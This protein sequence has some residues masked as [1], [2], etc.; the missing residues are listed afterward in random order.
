[1]WRSRIRAAGLLALPLLVGSLACGGGEE[2]DPAA[3]QQEAVDREMEAALEDPAAEPELRDEPDAGSAA[4]RTSP[5]AAAT[6]RPAPAPPP[7]PAAATPVETPPAET[8]PS[9]EPAPRSYTVPA[10]TGFRVELEQELSTRTNRVGDRFTVRTLE[11]VTDGRYV[12]APTGTVLTGRITA[13][14]KSGGAGDPAI[15]KIAFD[16]IL[17]GE[18]PIPLQA[19]VTEANPNV[20][21]RSGTGERAAK[22]GGGAVAGAILGRVIGGGAKGAVVGGVVGAAAG[23]A[24]TLATED[25]DAVLP[26]GSELTLELDEPLV[27]TEGA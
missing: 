8:S 27:V 26:A 4:P 5:Q 6:P 24:I 25:K 17:I 2:V 13:L 15:I 12:V 11:P 10:G 9:A 3:E 1:M 16:E 14:Q 7:P 21:R 18:T 23:T 22:I 19:T 20:E